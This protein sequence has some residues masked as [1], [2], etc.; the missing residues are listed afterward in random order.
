MRRNKGLLYAAG[1]VAV[2]ILIYLLM[3][4]STTDIPTYAVQ[5][6]DFHM[7]VVESG[8]VRAKDSYT[9]TAPRLLTA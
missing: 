6:A 9:V 1:A 8:T 2:V 4:G 5:R 3:P 7:R